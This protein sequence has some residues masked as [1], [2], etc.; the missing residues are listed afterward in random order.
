MPCMR[1]GAST[2]ASLAK[3]ITYHTSGTAA[4]HTLPV[5]WHSQL[6][7]WRS[8]PGMWL[9]EHKGRKQVVLLITPTAVMF[10][11]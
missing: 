9:S 1:Y 10:I 5:T 8:E 6:D 7:L 11:C 3:Q 4:K 2:Q